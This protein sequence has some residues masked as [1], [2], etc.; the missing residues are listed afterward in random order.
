[1]VVTGIKAGNRPTMAGLIKLAWI[2]AGIDPQRALVALLQQTC[3][4]ALAATKLVSSV[5]RLPNLFGACT[6]TS[7]YLALQADEVH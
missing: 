4:S 6:P 5:V 1:M 3:N 2:A 7:I